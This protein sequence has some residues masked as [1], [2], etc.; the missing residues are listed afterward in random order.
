MPDPGNH[1]SPISYRWTASF[2]TAFPETMRCM[3]MCYRSA[4][5][6]A[7]MIP[8]SDTSSRAFQHQMSRLWA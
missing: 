2:G 7:E 6:L 5:V 1:Y 3:E 4:C 8:A